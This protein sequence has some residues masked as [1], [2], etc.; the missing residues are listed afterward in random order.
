MRTPYSGAS[1]PPKAGGKPRRSR[2]KE[3]FVGG[4]EN[5][6]AALIDDFSK[7]FALEQADYHNDEGFHNERKLD[8][9][10]AGKNGGGQCL[11]QDRSHKRADQIEASP[12]QRGAADHGCQ[13]R[14]QFEPKA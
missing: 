11:N 7:G 1:P 6:C 9:D 4:R 5:S 8:G 13:N 12:L 2:E 3:Y 14:V 10:S